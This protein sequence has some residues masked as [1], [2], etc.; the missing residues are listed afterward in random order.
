MT[1]Y[2]PDESPFG[3]ALLFPDGIKFFSTTTRGAVS[4]LMPRERRAVEGASEKRK[5]EFAAGRMC[6]RRCMDLL[7]VPVQQVPM[8]HDRS[9]I[10]PSGLV[11]S[12]S[13]CD[14]Y[15]LAAVARSESFHPFGVDVEKVKDVD[16]SLQQFI[17]TAAEADALKHVSTIFGAKA[18]ALFFSAKEAV[19]KSF[20]PQFGEVLE[21]LDVTLEIDVPNGRFIGRVA[22]SR[23][24]AVFDGCF[25][26]DR[27]LVFTFA[28]RRKG[29]GVPEAN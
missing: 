12:I 6:A 11:G 23:S 19:F 21:F 13:H 4:W 10:W 15:A 9:P 2:L 8:G 18:L 5:G 28:I 3:L 27:G 7:F 29:D 26:I 1:P 14:G 24:I 16:K 25:F 17:C 22:R 20:Y